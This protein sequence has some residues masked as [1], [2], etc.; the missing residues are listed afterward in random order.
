[1]STISPRDAA[2]REELRKAHTAKERA[3]IPRAKM[4]ELPPAYRVTCNEEVNQGLSREQAVL[5]ATRCLDCPDPQCVTGCPVGINIPGFIKNIERENFGDAAIVLKETSALP[6]VCGRVCPQ[7]RQCESKCIYNKMKKEPVAIGYLERFAADTE[8]LSGNAALPAREAANGIKVAVVGSG[9]A[10]LSFAGDMAKRGFE[11]HV[12]EALHEIGGVLKYGIPEFRLPNE[13]VDVE[14]RAL[15]QMGVKFMTDCVVGKT[16]SYDDLLARDFRG[17]FVASGAGLPRFMGIPGENYVGVMSSN[18]YLTRVNL[19]GA[20]R[21]GWSTPVIR[22]HRVAVIGGGNTAMD[23]CRTARRMGA[24]EVY[25]VYRRSEAEMPARV[26]EVRHAKEEGVT[27]LTLHNPVEYLADE[28]GHVKAMRL[29]RMELGEPDASGRR[30]PV[31]VEGDVVTLDVDEVIVS[32]GVSPNPLIPNSIEGLEV[33]RR[34]TLAVNEDTLQ[35]SLPLLYAGGD[36]VRGGATVILAM[37]D[38]RKAAA[39]MADA[40]LNK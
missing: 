2:W 5:E 8:R 15:E 33:T 13:V 21:P 26:E 22:G 27:F 28:R 4:T 25:I 11:V 7:E 6:A 1:M 16:I 32:V 31:P 29:Q 30:S 10:S 36:I 14:I 19:M 34:G 3:A 24:E 35:T 23:S 18:E 20:G 40:L 37:G 12:Y 39:A 9:P 38:G 17:V